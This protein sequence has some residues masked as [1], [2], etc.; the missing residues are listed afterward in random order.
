MSP[1][2]PRKFFAHL[3]ADTIR[4]SQ[5]LCLM[6]PFGNTVPAKK[7]LSYLQ[8]RT[9]NML[10]AQIKLRRSIN[11]FK[12]DIKKLFLDKLQKDSDDM[13]I[14]YQP[15]L[16]PIYILIFIFY[17]IHGVSVYLYTSVHR[18][19]VYLCSRDHNENKV[20]H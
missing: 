17:V 9:W 8:P 18:I 20:Y 11:T 2:S 4:A 15:K 14:Y 19:S 12:H 1:K 5:R 10:P 16:P 6:Y 3:T 7:T 13:F